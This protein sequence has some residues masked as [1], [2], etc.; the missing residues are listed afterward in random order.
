MTLDSSKPFKVITQFITEDGTDA[1]PLQEVRQFYTQQG[2]VILPPAS[3]ITDVSA[4]KQAVLFGEVD[5]FGEYGGMASLNRDL[6]RGLV[7]VISIWDDGLTGMRWL[8]STFPP[9]ATGPGSA[10][11]PCTMDRGVDELRNAFGYVKAFFTNL[12]VGP[13]NSTQ[14]VTVAATQGGL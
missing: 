5:D 6:S 2:N 1:G 7:L 10:R 4:A 13:L 12:A 11:G 8:D 9:G 3:S 14:R